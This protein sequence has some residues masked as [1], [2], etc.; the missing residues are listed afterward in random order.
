M[1]KWFESCTSTGRSRSSSSGTCAYIDPSQRFYFGGGVSTVSS[2]PTT[3]SAF[4]SPQFVSAAPSPRALYSSVFEP[5]TQ[6]LSLERGGLCQKNV[7]PDECWM[8]LD[9]WD[10]NI[11]SA[12][13]KSDSPTRHVFWLLAFT[14]YSH[15]DTFGN[16]VFRINHGLSQVFC[17]FCQKE[18]RVS[19]TERGFEVQTE[20]VNNP[21]S[22]KLDVGHNIPYSAFSDCSDN[23]ERIKKALRRCQKVS[24]KN[25]LL[26]KLAE[27][28][29]TFDWLTRQ[30][31]PWGYSSS[32]CTLMC[33]ECNCRQQNMDNQTYA[34]TIG[35]FPPMLRPRNYLLNLSNSYTTQVTPENE[36]QVM[37][38]VLRVLRSRV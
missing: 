25:R 28:E 5:R 37:Q 36:Y 34:Q 24:R 6:Q 30:Y 17:S 13:V 12:K 3:P 11:R 20:E 31:G 14:N 9:G 18:F 29:R 22:H 23:I 7:C 1:S 38:E 32:N 8:D 19:W 26:Q 15:T 2:S 27:A 33:G 16:C 4:S 10:D 35:V 21:N